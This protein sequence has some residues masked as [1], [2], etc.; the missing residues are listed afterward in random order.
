VL[1]QR[2][3][4]VEE[5]EEEEERRQ[6]NMGGRAAIPAA[7]VPL[8][9]W[10][11]A[12]FE[13][14]AAFAP[15]TVTRRT[16]QISKHDAA[17]FAELPNSGKEDKIASYQAVTEAELSQF[18]KDL[19]QLAAIRPSD[20]SADQ[21]APIALIS[22]GSSY[23]RLWT[24]LT[25]LKHAD[26]PHV[27]YIRHI[28]KWPL[29]TSAK[30][31]FPAVI[32]SATYSLVMSYIFRHARIGKY[33]L[34]ATTKGAAAALGALTAPLALLLTLRANASLGRLNEA[35]VLWGRLILRGRNLASV[36]KVYVM[37][38]DPATAILAARYLSILGWSIKAMVR[39]ESASS[40]REVYEMMLGKEEAAWLQAQ[41]TKPPIAI[42][43][44]LRHL[45]AG[46]CMMSTNPNFFVP[47]SSMEHALDD[48]DA[49]TGGCERLLTSPI[50]PT[51]S[52]HLSRI[53]CLY[54]CILPLASVASGMPSLGSM[55]ASAIVSYVLVGV[56]E[57]GMEVENPFPL[58][59]LQQM[60]AG[61][62]SLVGETMTSS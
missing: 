38:I 15:G 27:R 10:S 26:P 30:K 31:I 4:V 1:I 5:E 16:Q 51:Y 47:H 55:L 14:I 42:V 60:S 25:W 56:D 6:Q 12:G 29:S 50:P 43:H 57:I 35:R 9:L 34:T 41:T 11:S 62:Q 37:P 52:R 20:P 8:L 61:L 48:L 7:A 22:A 46:V 44:R 17:L 45:I 23:T 2:S 24:P 13:G 36:L 53:M 49:T 28:S 19:Q 33:Q 3:K 59:P 32:I 18:S 21:S 58:L 39:N 40:Q 54:L